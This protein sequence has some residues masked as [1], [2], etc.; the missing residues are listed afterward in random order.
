M[1][2][3]EYLAALINFERAAFF[4]T[5]EDLCE[6]ELLNYITS[7]GRKAVTTQ[8]LEEAGTSGFRGSVGVGLYRGMTIGTTH[9]DTWLTDYTNYYRDYSIGCIIGLVPVS[10][11]E[12]SFETF[13]A[14]CG[15]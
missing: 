6:A 10:E 1:Q 11:I 2:E 8:I 9:R 13:L 12:S 5:E 14:E 7:I 3:N 15:S 4:I